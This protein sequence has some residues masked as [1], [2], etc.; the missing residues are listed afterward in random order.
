M[1]NPISAPQTPLSTQSSSTPQPRPSDHA[2]R[3]WVMRAIKLGIVGLLIWGGH[4]TIAGA[5]DELTQKNFDWTTIDVW[6]LVAASIVYLLGQFPMAIFW[7]TILVDL[8]QHPPW[9]RTIRANIIGHLGKYV[10]GKALV[11][12]IRTAMAKTPHV[13]TG[14]LVASIFYETFTSMAVG[15]ILALIVLLPLV[16]FSLP[17]WQ[18]WHWFDAPDA[19]QAPGSDPRMLL[20]ALGLAGA[21]G[22][23]TIPRVFDWVLGK[24]RK[25]RQPKP[26]DVV[27]TIAEDFEPAENVKHQRFHL[28]PQTLLLGWIGDAIAWALMGWSLWA[29]IR[30]FGVPLD[31]WKDWPLL[32]ACTSLAIVAGFVSLI[33]GGA[34][35]REL[36]FIL[37]LKP[38]V[39]DELLSVAIP[40]VLRVE[41]LLAELVL[42]GIFYVIPPKKVE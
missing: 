3:R 19:T 35:V 36:V 18:P 32:T 22:L 7:R 42:C 33:P 14:P 29:T 12:V 20:L 9:Y 4:K 1:T 5:Y 25:V 10:P 2:G 21:T 40:I 30:A 23:P 37:L 17:Y 8:G 39:N 27:E 24:L 26:G 16:D 41:W 11:V 28:R 38:L 34:G 15:S 13:R 6:W 31:L